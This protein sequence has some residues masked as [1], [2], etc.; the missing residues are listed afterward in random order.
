MKKNVQPMKSYANILTHE[1]ARKYEKL[2]E[3]V[4]NERFEFFF[5]FI[6]SRF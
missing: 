6:K 1:K 5:Y 2:N 3:K 4:K